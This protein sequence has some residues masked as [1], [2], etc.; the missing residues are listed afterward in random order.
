MGA[1]PAEGW[2]RVDRFDNQHFHTAI[3][4]IPPHEH[5]TNHYAQHQP[6][7]GSWGQRIEPPPIPD[8]FRSL[9]RWFG[10]TLQSGY[11]IGTGGRSRMRIASSGGIDGDGFTD[12]IA[13]DTSTG[14]LDVPRPQQW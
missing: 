5:E 9:P 11:L 7:T 3:G 12:L 6:P 1:P 10:N 14:T 2:G 4:D 13:R 8:W